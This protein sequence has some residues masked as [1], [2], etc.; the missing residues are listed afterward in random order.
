MR[1]VSC[2]LLSPAAGEENQDPIDRSVDRLVALGAEETGLGSVYIGGM[3][4]TYTKKKSKSR[5]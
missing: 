3:E 4:R 2:P 5:S 1:E